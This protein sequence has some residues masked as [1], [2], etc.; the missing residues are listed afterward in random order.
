MLKYK[1]SQA[2]LIF[3]LLIG[4]LLFNI[5]FFSF[6][7]ARNGSNGGGSIIISPYKNNPELKYFNVSLGNGLKI[8]DF[9]WSV[10]I[11][12]EFVLQNDNVLKWGQIP[13]NINVTFWKTKL[14]YPKPKYKY[15]V[16]FCG[17]NETQKPKVKNVNLTLANSENLIW[18]NVRKEGNSIIINKNG[19]EVI[20]SH[21]DILINYTIE[22]ITKQN[23]LIGNLSSN[24][25]SQGDGTYCIDF[26]PTITITE[27]QIVDD[28]L[29]IN[30]TAEKGDANFTH[31]NIS[32]TPPYD[33]LVGYWSFD[34]DN[35]NSKLNT[36]YDF[37]K[38]NNDGAMKG[39]VVV[40]ST[41]CMY[42]DCLHFDG[43]GD[44]VD[45]NEEG[46]LSIVGNLTISAWIYVKSTAAIGTIIGR[47]VAIE[48]GYEIYYSAQPRLRFLV[49]SGG[50]E[51][52]ECYINGAPAT[53]TWIHVVGVFN[54]TASK[55][56]QNG[57]LGK[58]QLNTNLAGT[59]SITLQIGSGLRGKMNG[60]IDEVMIFNTSL[61][62]TQILDIYNNQSARFFRQGTQKV[63]AVNITDTSNWQ[64]AGY[65]R[66][67]LTTTYET[68]MQSN[69]SARIGQMNLSVDPDGL[70][71]YMPFEWGSAVDIS[72]NS[73]DGTI[74]DA[75][76]NSTG[77]LNQTG[78]FEFDSDGDRIIV[79]DDDSLDMGTSD[80]TV[81]V[82]VKANEYE[83]SS[84]EIVDKR[85]SRT[86]DFWQLKGIGTGFQCVVY[87]GTDVEGI[88]VDTSAT[89][90]Q[91]LAF[92]YD[93]SDSAAGFRVYI[94]GSVVA[95]TD[96][97]FQDS[98]NNTEPLIIGGVGTVGFNGTIDQ[99][100][101]WNRSLSANEIT[102]LYGN[103]SAKYNVAYY[104]DYQNL[105]GTYNVFNIS[106]NADFIFPD[107]KFFAGNLTNPF[108]TPLLLGDITL[109]IWNY[110]A[111]PADTE[112]PLFSSY[113]DNNG[114]FEDSGT[115]Y[116]NVTVTHT[117]NT[118][119]LEIDDGGGS[120]AN[121]TT[122]N[123]SGDVYNVSVS[124]TSAGTYDY[125]FFSWGNGTNALYNYSETRYYTV[126]TSDTCT[127]SASGHWTVDC[128]DECVWDSNQN[129]PAN[130]SMIGSG[131]ATLMHGVNFTFATKPYYVYIGS[132][133]TFVNNGGNFV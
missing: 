106:A 119:L 86:T 41:N 11:Q 1:N 102:A 101:I 129:I 107:F 131:S 13:K 66:V 35:V 76:F 34:G 12:A 3:G 124:M 58:T 83:S 45:I 100:I 122:H 8:S 105:S 24:F 104:T 89:T 18:A 6:V 2:R 56:Y 39:D 23:I 17:I 10:T 128:S 95:D 112:Y 70:V 118:V 87:N 85:G 57:I 103:Q 47:E 63:R 113:W 49:N 73:N 36:S 9:N 117:N 81:S 125:K 20:L 130:I 82:W 48:G 5:I 26:D 121:Y 16:T 98:I 123:S 109:D 4:F 62:A 52:D 110:T 33:S 99:V 19:R 44:Y 29:L 59:T 69:I 50:V 28:S 91:H 37:S 78:G 65:N 75:V 32:T 22:Q 88:N 40:N 77:G 51:Y 30:V 64:D 68:N 46:N 54:G 55:I 116:F 42:G 114:T 84:A 115:A 25:V 108:Y 67:N 127:A 21:S 133:C 92:T 14:N 31:L 71:L 72:G 126:N 7:L 27:E 43:D 97:T 120:K 74:T 61:T 111:P 80:W 132:G 94:N 53:N 38:E 93:R 90:W 79:A 60:T 15:G 96:P